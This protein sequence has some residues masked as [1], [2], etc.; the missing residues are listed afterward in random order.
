MAYTN[1]KINQYTQ[2]DDKISVFEASPHRLVQMLLEGAI[3]KI[4]IAKG[5]MER[6]SHAE[7]GR[8]VSW[9]ISII[10]GLRSS[11][12]VKAG[13]EMANNLDNLYEY[14]G[15]RLL[16]ANMENDT[17][18]LTEVCNLLLEIKS[19]WDAIPD[20]AKS[21]RAR[22]TDNPAGENILRAGV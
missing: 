2:H 15:H 10:D 7:K 1:S 5:H 8:H 9:A 22:I 17:T 14:M 12:D 18:M 3:E 20:E 16:Q 4:H 6:G 19:A 11:V 13:G 21:V